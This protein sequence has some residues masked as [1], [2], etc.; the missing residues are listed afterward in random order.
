MRARFKTDFIF[1]NKYTVFINFFIKEFSH[2]FF[3]QLF[4]IYPF[5]L[6]YWQIRNH[7]KKPTGMLNLFFLIHIGKFNSIFLFNYWVSTTTNIYWRWVLSRIIYFIKR[8]EAR[9]RLDKQLPGMLNW[10]LPIFPIASLFGENDF[11]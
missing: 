7:Y 1:S 3:L 2:I 6:L 9:C 4:Y 11:S 5:I 8:F 10:L